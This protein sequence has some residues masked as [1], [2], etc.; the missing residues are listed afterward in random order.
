M[1]NKDLLR[2]Y[3][4]TGITLREYQVNSLS[5]NLFRTYI[6]KRLIA[7]EQ[8]DGRILE[9]EFDLMT[10]EVKPEYLK[11]LLERLLS[12][13]YKTIL[14]LMMGGSNSGKLEKWEYDGIGNYLDEKKQKEYLNW[15]ITES[16]ILEEWEFNELDYKN[17][18]RYIK[19]MR[20]INSHIGDNYE[21]L[22]RIDESIIRYKDI[23]DY[24]K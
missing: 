21:K 10:D 2:Q 14:M 8:T 17:K 23:L 19:L 5:P 12:G 7:A 22:M 4:D 11:K 24:G 1:D 15:R 20:E 13:K 9:Y 3:V 16:S 18:L 6:R